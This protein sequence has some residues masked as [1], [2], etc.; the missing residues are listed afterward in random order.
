MN[1]L[2]QV[3]LNPTPFDGPE[4][5]AGQRDFGGWL[6]V[7]SRNRD[8]DLLTQSNWDGFLEALGGEGENV[9][10][11]R[12]G[13][14]AFGWLEHITVAPGTQE[15]EKAEE[16]RVCLEDYPVLDDEDYSRREWESYGEGWVNYAARDFAKGLQGKFRL[17][18][19]SFD[20]LDDNR[21]ALREYFEACIPSG[22]YYTP[23]SDGVSVRTDSALRNATRD[24]VAGLLRKIRNG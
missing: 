2:E 21:E 4:N 12:F 9:Q 3:A 18:D 20:L 19:E 16:L 11:H 8:S 5:Y 17:S 6:V 22:E 23:D 1:T 14:W 15:A 13:H 10:I 7:Y 24:G